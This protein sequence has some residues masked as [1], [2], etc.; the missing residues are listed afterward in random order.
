[1]FLTFGA[2]GIRYWIILLW[3]V[4]C[5]PVSCR[6]FSSISSLYSLDASST[7]QIQRRPRQRQMSP[8]G[9]VTLV[10]KHCTRERSSLWCMEGNRS[11]NKLQ[12]QTTLDQ[13]NTHPH[14][15]GLAGGKVCVYMCNS[16][17]SLLLPYTTC[18]AFNKILQEREKQEKPV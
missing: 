7:P 15:E 6:I 14:A 3:R 11:N 2:T 13:I 4:G 17:I 9:K 8:G 18:Q 5:C 1:M 16:I 10:E 12:S